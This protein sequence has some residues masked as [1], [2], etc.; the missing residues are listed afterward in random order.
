MHKRYISVISGLIITILFSCENEIKFD[1]LPCSFINYRYD[2]DGYTYY[3]NDM[4][5]KYVLIGIDSINKNEVLSEIVKSKNYLDQTYD[6]EIQQFPYYD[7]KYVVFKLNRI[8]S[9]DEI[10]WILDDLQ[11]NPIIV[12][13][14]YTLQSDDCPNPVFYPGE[15]LC[16]DIYKNEFEVKV[17]NHGDTANLINLS[18]Q[19]NTKVLGHAGFDSSLC[20]LQADKFS[21][22]DALEMANYFYETGLFKYTWINF[23]LLGVEK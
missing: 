1:K 22:G 14:H 15:K 21:M 2:I 5:E 19:T 3:L 8:Y 13:A 18:H 11:Q 20:I 9:C 17:N 16:V 4:S 12:F 23:N 10:A 6:Y 7:H